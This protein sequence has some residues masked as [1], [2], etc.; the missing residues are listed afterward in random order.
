MGRLA[1]TD[2]LSDV[3]REI[4]ATV[5]AFVDRDVIPV[6][7]ELEHRDEYPSEIVERMKEMGL[8]GLMIPE[9]YGGLGE[10]LLTYAL[11]VEE[12]SRGWMSVS[13]IVNTHFIVAYMIEQHGTP[14]QK[15]HFLPEM[16]EGRIRG[17]F[18]MSEP[19]CGSD[20]SAIRTKA[21]RSG[22]EYVIDGQKMWLTNGGSANLVA[23]LAKTDEGAGSVYRNMTTFLVEKEPGFGET[24]PGLTIPGKIDKMGYKGVDTTEMVL[25]GVRV[26][27]GRVLGGVPGQG[28]Y[29]MMDGVEVGRVNVAARGCGVAQRAFEL[30]IR[31]AQ[32]RETFGKALHE[33]QAIQFKLAEMATKVEAAHQMMVMAARKKDAG[34]RNDLEAGMAKYLAAEYCKEVV[35]DAFRIHGGYGYSKEFEIERLYREA[36]MLLIGEGTSEIQKMIIGRRLL[37]EYRLPE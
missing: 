26:P 32:Q 5:R 33:H 28:F 11:V 19:H 31:Y 2:G 14:E 35:E 20:V 7:T 16:A 37:E 18:S 27:A 10:S 34:E 25:D 29:Q 21:V 30:G 1:Q 36:P 15:E 3:Q 13:G 12:L 9:E 22:E 4:L 6:A 23:V 24:R 17:A 8:F